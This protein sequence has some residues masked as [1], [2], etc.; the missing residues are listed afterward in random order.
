MPS[1]IQLGNWN[2][3][4]ITGDTPPSVITARQ[5][6]GNS[7]VPVSACENPSTI[8]DGL[9]GNTGD[10]PFGIHTA[11]CM[12]L[13]ITTREHVYALHISRKTLVA[14]I[15]EEFTK[16]LGNEVIEHVYIGP[17]I[18][19]KCFT[20]SFI[21]EDVEKFAQMFPY[22]TETRGAITHLSLLKV[23]MRFLEDK[24]VSKKDIAH[25]GR[26]TF[27]TPELLSYRRWIAEG[28]TGVFP[29]IT[30]VIE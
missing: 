25:D 28:N 23:V 5:V 17:H 14:G 18:C 6:H 9:V 16:Q 8:A 1:S 20:F 19:E 10:K 29:E 13:V 11:D 30:T 7:I 27:E 12:P 22:A 24:S 21:G 3:S 15:L 4:Q 2:V 26:C